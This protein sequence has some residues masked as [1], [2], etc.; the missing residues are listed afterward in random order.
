MD[1]NIHLLF[2]MITTLVP[3]IYV[4]QV[5]DVTTKPLYAMIAM[6]AQMMTATHLP[7]VTTML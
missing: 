6:L 7:V 4:T 2:A 1:A 5:L 3:M